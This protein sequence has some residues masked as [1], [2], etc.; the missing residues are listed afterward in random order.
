MS[1]PVARL[2]TALEDRYAIERDLGEG[3][4]GMKGAPP[5][6]SFP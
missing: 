1:D 5:G 2:N 4:G 3:S 6:T